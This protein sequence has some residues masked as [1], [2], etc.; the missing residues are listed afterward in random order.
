MKNKVKAWVFQW[1]SGLHI[2]LRAGRAGSLEAAAGAGGALAL[3]LL[4]LGPP[5]AAGRALRAG[6]G[7]GAQ[8]LLKAASAVVRPAYFRLKRVETRTCSY[9]VI[10]VILKIRSIAFKFIN[11]L[12]F[13]KGDA[14]DVEKLVSFSRGLGY[15]SYLGPATGLETVICTDLA[16]LSLSLLHLKFSVP[17][18]AYAD[19]WI[20]TIY[21]LTQ[22]T[23][24][25]KWNGI[26]DKFPQ[27]HKC[28][29]AF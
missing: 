6:L 11:I 27:F 21:S 4:L 2:R 3:Q 23:E 15:H 20:C 12:V 19:L 29:N 1:D 10:S 13:L 22:R 17:S 28:V 14:K 24:L 9:F 5:G 7:R 25:I 18:G 8:H 26:L 16:T